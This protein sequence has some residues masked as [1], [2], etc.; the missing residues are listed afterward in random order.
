M[1]LIMSVHLCIQLPLL[2][3]RTSADTYCTRTSLS[4]YGSGLMRVAYAIFSS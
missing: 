1:L 3:V 4:S 2:P